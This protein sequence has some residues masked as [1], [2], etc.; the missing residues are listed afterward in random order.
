MNNVDCNDSTFYETLIE[1]S[2][3]SRVSFKNAK[4]LDVKIFDN[5]LEKI[6]F[7]NSDLRGAKF[8]NNIT[9]HISIGKAFLDSTEG[10]EE[11][12][13]RE[14]EETVSKVYSVDM[15]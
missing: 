15:K 3:F 13:I 1:H 8:R 10:L 6:H 2:K 7:H 5:E 4:L 12:V 9:S 11:V 14:E